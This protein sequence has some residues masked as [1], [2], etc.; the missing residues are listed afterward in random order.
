MRLAQIDVQ[1]GQYDRAWRV[2]A[3]QC[4]GQGKPGAEQL[5]VLTLE[6]Q[7]KKAEA[8]AARAAA[9]DIPT[10]PIWPGSMPRLLAKDGKPAE[11][12]RVLGRVPR[13]PARTTRPWS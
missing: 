8:R 13:R 2:D 9:P 4:A 11:A 5:A 6:E 12:D 10:A 1:L 7:G 3:L